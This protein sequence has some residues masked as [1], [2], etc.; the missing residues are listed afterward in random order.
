MVA[1]P[2]VAMSSAQSAK[3][4]REQLMNDFDIFMMMLDAFKIPYLTF[5]AATDFDILVVVNRQKFW[6]DY[7]TGA[8]F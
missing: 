1:K 4:G 7:E 2:I 5:Q 3:P 8:I 6:F